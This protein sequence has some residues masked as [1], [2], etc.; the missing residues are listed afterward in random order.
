MFKVLNEYGI[1]KRTFQAWFL[2]LLLLW[3]L[4]LTTPISIAAEVPKGEAR[5]RAAII[6]GILRYTTWNGEVEDDA[7]LLICSVGKTYSAN[8]LKTEKNRVNVH[9]RKLKL[10][11][12]QVNEDLSSCPVVI[13]GDLSDEPLP[14]APSAN[15]INQLT[16]CDGCSIERSPAIIRLTRQGGRIG[17]EVN[18]AK[19]KKNGLKFSSDMLELATIVEGDS[20]D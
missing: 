13:Y 8:V 4:G 6:V 11:P 7:E 18:L 17:I 14:A 19:A 16:I 10:T 20:N 1:P 12:R 3:I 2:V 9:G 5:L 15:Y